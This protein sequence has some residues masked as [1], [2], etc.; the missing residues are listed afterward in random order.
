MLSSVNKC[1]DFSLFTFHFSVN[2]LTNLFSSSQIASSSGQD[3][4]V[5][6][7]EG[8]FTN[9]CNDV[10]VLDS[11]DGEEK[12]VHFSIPKERFQ[13]CSSPSFRNKVFFHGCLKMTVNVASLKKSIQRWRV[14]RGKLQEERHAINPMEL[15]SIE[16]GRGWFLN[17][18]LLGVI[19]W[20]A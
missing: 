1:D 10:E 6:T 13:S 16:G 15:F 19:Q 8:Y 14:K 7:D 11:L 5:S 9:A 2:K 20:I 3:R 4:Y 12:F 18:L 17:I